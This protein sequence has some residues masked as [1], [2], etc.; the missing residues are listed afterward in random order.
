[1]L[2]STI[3]IP[4]LSSDSPSTRTSSRLGTPS[5][6]KVAVTATGS[7]A[8]IS[9][10][11]SSAAVIGMP[12]PTWTIMPTSTV[13]ITRATIA[14]ARIG[15]RFLTKTRAGRVSAA[16]KTSAGRK[17]KSSTSW[18]VSPSIGSSIPFARAISPAAKPTR[19]RIRVSGTRTRRVRTASSEAIASSDRDREG[20]LGDALDRDLAGRHQG[21]PIAAPLR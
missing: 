7:V 18:K 15:T 19:T 9:A 11:K 14:R 8:E 13:A 20:D 4:S 17:A 10:P 1:M 6:R 21:E 3:A 2:K 5:S 12:R 16:S